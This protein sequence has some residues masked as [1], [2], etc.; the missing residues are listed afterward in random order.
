MMDFKSK[1]FVTG[2]TGMMGSA[3][4]RNLVARGYR[5]LILKTRQELDLTQQAQVEQFFQEE[6]PDYVFLS[7]AKVGG[8][9]ANHTYPAEF[10]FR[11]L[12]IQTHVI[13]AAYRHSVKRLLFLGSS[14]IYPKEC[15]QPMKEEH[16]L[17]GYLEPT[18]EPYAIAKIAG[19]KMCEAYNRQYGTQFLSVV[20][21]N[22][23]GEGDNFDLETNHVLPALI[24]K[25]HEG[26]EQG[27]SVTIWGTGRPQRELLYIDDCAEACVLLMNL[28][29]EP[30]TKLIRYHTGPLI[31]V[32]TGEGL[33]IREL[34]K[35]IK[36]IVGFEGHVQW[37]TTK[38]DGTMKKV[39]D[40]SRL[41][42]LGWRPRFSLRDGIQKTYEYYCQMVCQ[43]GMMNTIA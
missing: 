8:I 24:R 7:A 17:S 41:H 10:I 40:I 16:L 14:C 5:N 28:P 36:Q 32:G 3:L 20:P 18:N 11:N 1:I 12:M 33:T 29:T 2:H 39:L 15:P 21:T 19:V 13:D 27:T 34:V 37:D 9:L 26:C 31:N 30:Y 23:Y 4:V 22:L 25:F 42:Q 35:M 38:P 43:M 6:Q